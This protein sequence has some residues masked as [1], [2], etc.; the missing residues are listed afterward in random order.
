ML[1]LDEESPAAAAEV[2]RRQN[3]IVEP[4]EPDYNQRP[5]IL[6]ARR[7]AG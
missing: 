5:R 3:W 6:I 1:E 4:V 7:Q 2:F